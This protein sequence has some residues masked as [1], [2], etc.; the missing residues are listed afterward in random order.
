MN[1][2]PKS[3][4]DVSLSRLKMKSKRLLQLR[5]L[6]S[7]LILLNKNKS[8]ATLMFRQPRLMPPS[9][10]KKERNNKLRR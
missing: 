1:L 5:H 9:I 10:A 4:E 7:L 3:R 6:S 8:L 2:L